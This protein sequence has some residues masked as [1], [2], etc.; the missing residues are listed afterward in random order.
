[1]WLGDGGATQIQVEFASTGTNLIVRNGDGTVLG[2]AVTTGDLNVWHYYELKVVFHATAGSVILKRDGATLLSLTNVKTIHSANASADTAWFTSNNSHCYYDDIYMCDA[3][4]TRN[5]DFLGDCRVTIWVPTQ[6]GVHTD[7]TPSA[8]TSHYACVDEIPSNGDTDYVSSGTVGAIET[9]RTPAATF[10]GTV[11]GLK[12]SASARKD[13]AGYRSI[14]IVVGDGVNP[15]T[16]LGADF[17]LTTAYTRQV[18]A[19]ME[20]NPLTGNPWALADIQNSEF[21]VKVTG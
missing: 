5:N 12:V 18:T 14:G 4:G 21:G 1:M 11:K 13:D 8:G 10:A 17:A 20:V 2:T 19:V 7:F 3:S 9:Y 15:V 6:D 16:Q